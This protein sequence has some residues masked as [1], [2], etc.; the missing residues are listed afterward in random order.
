MHFQ[1]FKKSNPKQSHVFKYIH[2][3]LQIC[4]IFQETK[5]VLTEYGEQREFCPIDS[6]HVCVFRHRIL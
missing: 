5:I 6:F 4:N 2:T 1:N 3:Y